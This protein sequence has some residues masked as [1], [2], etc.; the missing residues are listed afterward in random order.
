L[1]PHS[2][3]A[4]SADQL[5]EEQLSDLKEVFSLFD[6][7]SDELI[8]KSELGL[9][10][11]A[12]GQNPTEIELQEMI[13]K[14]DVDDDGTI[15]LTEFLAMM[16]QKMETADN[17]SSEAEEA[18]RVFDKNCEGSISAVE[19]RHIMTGLGLKLTPE[20]ADEMIREADADQDGRVTYQDFLTIMTTL[21]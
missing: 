21:Q 7:D 3:P 1:H 18:F 5:T 20:E 10:M 15:S 16:A 19:L 17:L 6:K 12:L 13:T 8:V 4:M 2:A 14:G 9:V 11:R